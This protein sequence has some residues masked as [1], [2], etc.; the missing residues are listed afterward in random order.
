M[1]ALPGASTTARIAAA[2]VVDA[3]DPFR[4]SVTVQ[5]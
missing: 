1:V 4:E 3:V 5:V 2:D